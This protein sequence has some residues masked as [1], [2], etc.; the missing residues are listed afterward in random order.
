MTN[1]WGEVIDAALTQDLCE[2][3]VQQSSGPLPD[4]V[5]R[6]A[7]R[8]LLNVLATT[9]GASHQPAVDILV[10]H[11]RAHGG[12][13]TIPL[14]GRSE[15][16][17]P[18]H[19]AL[20]IGFAGHLDDFDD[21]HL[22]TVIHPGAATLAATYV[23]ALET[24]ATGADA[25][26]AFALGCEAQLRIGSAMSPSHYDTGWHIT[27]TCGVIGAA[28][29][30]GL[31]LGLT[32]DELASTVGIAASQTVGVREAFGTMTKPFHPGKAAANGILAARLATSGFTGNPE[33]LEHRQGYFAALSE[34]VDPDRLRQDY[35]D[36]WELLKNTY[37]PYPCGIVIHPVIDAAIGLHDEEAP[38]IAAIEFVR[39][40]CHPLVV[41]LTGNPDPAD[42]LEARFSAIH[43]AAVGLA[44]GRAGLPQYA[45]ERVR[46]QELVELRGKTELVVDEA[47]ERD[48]A[49]VEVRLDGRSVQH[50]VD[51]A[52]GSLAR[53]LSDEELEDKVRGLVEPVLPGVTELLLA[54]VR[55]LSDGGFD[56][57]ARACIPD[58]DALEQTERL[59]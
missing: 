32:A 1:R 3:L 34:E 47:L 33:V 44:E 57:L 27:G 28:I 43:G 48:A 59:P 25:L 38:D 22:E 6:E 52:R 24:R 40:R 21:T 17:D 13:G 18:I 37:K 5:E 49:T 2:A 29:A 26:T 46:S 36:G 51:H 14:P 35:E 9:I 30:A 23:T 54:R 45:D 39:I 20:V 53:P 10:A 41:E 56:E 8:T 58:H 19:A 7:R 31:L 11:S 42:G 16:T 12:E 15:R 4:A 55:Q 50:H